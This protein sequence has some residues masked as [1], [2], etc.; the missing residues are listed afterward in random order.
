MKIID[1]YFKMPILWDMVI[2]TF[3]GAIVWYLVKRVGLK[4]NIDDSNLVSL[5]NQLISSSVSIAGFII[6]ALTII[7]TFK[8]NYNSRETNKST[9]NYVDDKKTS[10]NTD[11]PKS[12]IEILFNS[13]HYK[14]I[15][16]VF[17]WSALVLIFAFFYFSVLLIMWK[18]INCHLNYCLLLIYYGLGLMVFATLRCLIVLYK[19]IK[20][21]MTN[22]IV[23]K[24]EKE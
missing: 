7:V 5:L 15:V 9:C 14:T 4:L 8:E 24:E 18:N 23:V 22:L 21:Q 17:F 16:G 11:E 2:L 3:A 1:K 13:H 20:L 12:G 6:A 19:V 10:E